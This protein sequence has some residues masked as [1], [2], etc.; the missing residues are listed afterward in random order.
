M[1][2]Y[3]LL[4]EALRPGGFFISDDISDNFAFRDFFARMGVGFAVVRCQ[5]KHV[6]IARK[7]C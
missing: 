2:A 4:W 6:G 5:E 1:F 7:P 3:P